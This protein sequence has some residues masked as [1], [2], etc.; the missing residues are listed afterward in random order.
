[1]GFEGQR[2]GLFLAQKHGLS[3]SPFYS[4]ASSFSLFLIV[5]VGSLLPESKGQM[6]KQLETGKGKL[7][8][9]SCLEAAGWLV[10]SKTWER[11]QRCVACM[12]SLAKAC[13][14]VG[15]SKGVVTNLLV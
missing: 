13:Y 9:Q 6:E 4:H 7:R 1:M 15:P 12:E 8:T 14:K 5:F 11:K 10:A 3:L 2:D